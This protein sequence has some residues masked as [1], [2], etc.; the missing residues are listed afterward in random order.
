MILMVILTIIFSCVSGIYGKTEPPQKTPIH[1]F[2]VLENIFIIVK[3]KPYSIKE[4]LFN[5]VIK[6]KEIIYN[7]KGIVYS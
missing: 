3:A 6:K 1:I 2:F 4:K 5:I 7:I